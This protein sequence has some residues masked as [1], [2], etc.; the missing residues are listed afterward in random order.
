MR[1]L[2]LLR[3]VPKRTEFDSL[4]LDVASLGLTMAQYMTSIQMIV[5]TL[6]TMLYAPCAATIVMIKRK[7][8]SAY[9]WE[10]FFVELGIAIIFAGAIRWIYVLIIVCKSYWIS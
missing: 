7:L 9:A 1:Y 4:A 5:F 10:I 8:G 6:T 3:S 2:P